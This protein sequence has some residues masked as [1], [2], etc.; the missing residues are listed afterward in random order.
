MHSLSFQADDPSNSCHARKFLK[1]KTE[2]IWD[3]FQ[4]AFLSPGI[5]FSST[6]CAQDD[7]EFLIVLHTVEDSAKLFVL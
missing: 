2:D 3:A 7:M 4:C 5:C 1:L 6:R